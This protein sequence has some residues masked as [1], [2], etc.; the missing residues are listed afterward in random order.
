ML[1]LIQL[2]ST[3]ISIRTVAFATFTILLFLGEN[4][5]VPRWLTRAAA[6]PVLF[7]KQVSSFLAIFNSKLCI[8]PYF[9]EIKYFLK[10]FAAVESFNR[11]VFHVFPIILIHSF[12][13]FGKHF[14]LP[15]PYGLFPDKRVFSGTG[16]H[17]VRQQIPSPCP[18]PPGQLSF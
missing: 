11:K 12:S 7:S 13:H 14:F 18:V 1:I 3:H 2:L 8:F 5:S 4:R 16:L 6:N 15:F 17:F 10:I 9:Q